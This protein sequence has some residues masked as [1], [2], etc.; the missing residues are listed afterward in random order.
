MTEQDTAK[1]IVCVCGKV[2]KTERGRQSHIDAKARVNDHGHFA[3]PEPEPEPQYLGRFRIPIHPQPGIF[4]TTISPTGVTHE[5]AMEIMAEPKWDYETAHHAITDVLV[6][7]GWVK[8][9][10]LGRGFSTL[11]PLPVARRLRAHPDRIPHGL[12]IGGQP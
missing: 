2:F 7:E 6:E 1:P 4:E 10:D 5:Q 9:H 11:V 12:T 3:P 8:V